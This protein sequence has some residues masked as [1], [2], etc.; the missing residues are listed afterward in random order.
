[1]KNRS[2]IHVEKKAIFYRDIALNE[3]PSDFEK[4]LN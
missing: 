3:R 4:K 1:M 2:E